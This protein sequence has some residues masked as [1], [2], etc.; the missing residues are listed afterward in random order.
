MK[1]IFKTFKVSSI[2]FDLEIIWIY[3]HVTGVYSPNVETLCWH[4]IHFRVYQTRFCRL[5]I[6][7]LTIPSDAEKRVKI[8]TENILKGNQTELLLQ[9]EFDVM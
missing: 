8:L 3:S 6:G 5:S 2:N 7:G 4:Q 9:V 1:L